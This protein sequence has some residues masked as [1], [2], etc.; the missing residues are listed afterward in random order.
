[1]ET[2]P[3]PIS[4]LGKTKPNTKKH[5]F[6]DQKK[7]TTTQNK[8]LK[9]GLVASYHI[10]HQN[11]EDLFLFWCFIN[12]SLTYLTHLPTYLQ[13]WDPQGAPAAKEDNIKQP[14]IHAIFVFDLHNGCKIIINKTTND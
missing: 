2:F 1:L 12:L 10:R 3:K 9:P 4:W 5:A 11:G 13:P 8:Q 7:C 14:R 6:T